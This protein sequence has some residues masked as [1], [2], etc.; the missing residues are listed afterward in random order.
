M[1]LEDTVGA[2]QFGER[3]QN[4][5][6]CRK[7]KTPELLDGIGEGKTRG[8]GHQRVIEVVLSFQDHQLLYLACIDATVSLDHAGD[9][10][11]KGYEALMV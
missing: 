2:A 6:T 11:Q 8:F 4:L 10:K 1:T 7:V 5:A 9:D 3:L